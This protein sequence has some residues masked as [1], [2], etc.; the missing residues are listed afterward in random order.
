[1]TAIPAIAIYTAHPGNAHARTYGR[2]HAFACD[3]F[4]DNLMA[5]N[6]LWPKRRQVAFHDVQIG[7]AHATGEDAK[8]Q[9]A[10]DELRARNFFDK[11]RRS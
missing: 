5:G 8:Q 11:Q 4:A 2:F 1:M 3:D 10:G 9:M 6:Q 7:A